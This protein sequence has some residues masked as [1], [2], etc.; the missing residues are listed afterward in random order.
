MGLCAVHTT[1]PVL[2]Y[3]RVEETERRG[4]R[5]ENGGR[6]MS[7]GI[8]NEVKKVRVCDIKTVLLL[9]C[10]KWQQGKEVLGILHFTC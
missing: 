4:E 9:A 8:V 1:T 3:H 10:L 6:R 7:S 2:H 5:M